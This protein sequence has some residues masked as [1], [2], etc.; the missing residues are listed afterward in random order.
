MRYGD[1]IQ[2]NTAIDTARYVRTDNTA[3]YSGWDTAGYSGSAAEWIDR[4][5]R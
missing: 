4:E 1:T 2:R 5:S 3:G